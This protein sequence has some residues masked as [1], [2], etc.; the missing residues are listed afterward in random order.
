MEAQ[1]EITDLI[2]AIRKGQV[3][4]DGPLESVFDRLQTFECW[5]SFFHL[6]EQQIDNPKRRQLAHYVRTARAYSVHLEDIHKAARISLKMMKD[7]RLSYQEFREKAL[8][9]IIDEQDYGNEGI[10]LQAI[11]PKLKSKEDNIACMERLCLIYEKKKYDEGNLNK[12]YER[13][14]ELDPY[15]QKALRYFKIVYTQNNQWDKVAQ[16]LIN[17]F[18]S[19]KH[20]NDRYRSAQELAAVYLYQLDEPGNSIEVLERHCADS[21]LSIFAI[22]YEAYYRMQNW[23]GCLK[24]LQDQIKKV[25]GDLNRALLTLRV[26]EMFEKLRRVDEAIA[27]YKRVLDLAP[28]MLEPL[29]KL[30]DIYLRQEDWTAV[31]DTLNILDQSL[32]DQFLK[33]KVREGIERLQGALNDNARKA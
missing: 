14:I 9:A 15:N 26:G 18:T 10:L 8:Y 28:N 13:L 12:S 2:A 17:L 1:L 3:T 25:S 27:A 32:D 24:V 23:E 16:V 30:S 22:H 21:P 5:T 4:L 7:L 33:N 31:I 19:A 29:E 6:L 20:V 11:Y